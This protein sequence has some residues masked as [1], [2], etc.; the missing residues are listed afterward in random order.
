ML[1]PMRLWAIGLLAFVAVGCRSPYG[2]FDSGHQVH[3]IFWPKERPRKPISVRPT[4]T[5]GAQVAESLPRTIGGKGGA[6]AIEV[7]QFR[8]PTGEYRLSIWEPRTRIEA[9][10][11]LDVTQELWIVLVLEK[12][13]RNGKVNVHDVPPE[14]LDWQPLVAVPD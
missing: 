13:K 1:L 5:L 2:Q 11:D 12:G 6:R 10:V 8:A 14:R 9:R 3:V 7:A 4:C